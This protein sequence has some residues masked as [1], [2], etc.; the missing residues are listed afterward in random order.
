M[1]GVREVAAVGIPDERSGEV[2]VLFVVRQDPALT[3]ATIQHFCHQQLTGYKQPRHVYFRD[4][5]P[6]TNVGKILR[7]SLRDELIRSN[8]PS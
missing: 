1:P 7:R 6:K 5:L 4:E 2:V 8:P 3:E